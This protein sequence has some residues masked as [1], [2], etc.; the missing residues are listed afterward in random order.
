MAIA[1]HRASHLFHDALPV[2]DPVTGCAEC[3]RLTTLAR[4]AED[5]F[6]RSAAV[7]VRVRMRRHH[8]QAHP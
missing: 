7:D 4:T 2:P 1:H 5:T 6:D 3:A 8:G